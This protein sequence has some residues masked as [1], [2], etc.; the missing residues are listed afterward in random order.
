MKMQFMGNNKEILVE[1][2]ELKTN[3]D[4]EYKANI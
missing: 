4:Y 1:S 2:K 3:L